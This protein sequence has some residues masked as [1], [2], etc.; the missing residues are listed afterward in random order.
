MGGAGS[1]G[2]GAG[3]GNGG[4]G[5]SLVA[6]GTL[7]TVMLLDGRVSVNGN[8]VGGNY[9]GGGAGGGIVVSA[10]FLQGSGELSADG[11]YGGS[12]GG[13]GG[14]GG[15][16]AIHASNS[17]F[18][19]NQHVCGGRYANSGSSTWYRNGAAGTLFQAL[20][21][22]VNDRRETLV[23]DNCGLDGSQ[24]VLMGQ[25][26]YEFVVATL[27]NKGRLSISNPSTDPDSRAFLLIKRL[28]GDGSGSL[29]VVDKTDFMVL[30]PEATALVQRPIATSFA[31]P[32]DGSLQV[33]RDERVWF[34]E[35]IT[36][37]MVNVDVQ[38]GA[39]LTLPPRLHVTNVNF[40]LAGALKG[41]TYFLAGL[42]S[43]ITFE[44]SAAQGDNAS[45]KPAG[46]WSFLVMRITRDAQF[47]WHSMRR[48][49]VEVK[50]EVVDEA[51]LQL[52]N[53]NYAT[54]RGP[55]L[56]INGTSHV[57]FTGTC[58]WDATDNLIIGRNARLTSVGGGGQS[59]HTTDCPS[60]GNSG[61]GGSHAGHGGA[62]SGSYTVSQPCDSYE[63]PQ[64]VG[65]AG[66]TWSGSTGKG[67]GGV[68]LL[69]NRTF[70]SVL[71]LDGEVNMAATAGTSNAGG[72]AGGS[73]AVG[74]RYFHGAGSMSVTGGN[75]RGGGS[76][77]RIAV[78]ATFTHGPDPDNVPWAGDV[79]AWGGDGSVEDGAA[80]SVFWSVGVLA[81]QRFRRLYVDNNNR[82]GRNTA[83]LD[84]GREVYEFDRVFIDRKAKLTFSPPDTA[85]AR[86]VLNIKQLGGD[87]SGT[88]NVPDRGDVQI[89]GPI[90]DTPAAVP[91]VMANSWVNSYARAITRHDVFYPTS[92]RLYVVN[93]VVG[94]QGKVVFPKNLVVDGVSLDV[95]GELSGVEWLAVKNAGSMYL[96]GSSRQTNSTA[97]YWNFKEINIIQDSSLTM[98]NVQNITIANRVDIAD[99]SRYTLNGLAPQD[100]GSWGSAV[101]KSPYITFNDTSVVTF[102]GR[103]VLD[104]RCD[105]ALPVH[106]ARV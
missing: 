23:V 81:S 40:R 4:A 52:T 55:E 85:P 25:I 34:S 14:S 1:Q 29:V 12:S 24:T 16:I 61:A 21:R 83:L 59:Q 60:S 97:G 101:I 28:E 103:L 100:D 80:G 19:G 63:W 105:P 10:F 87:G 82:V 57:H 98:D 102:E 35:A 8:N 70:A 7:D 51:T 48:L 44:A 58:T 31:L 78:H 36:L 94:T 65:Q 15:R 79:Y 46:L 92:Y 56:E 74:A 91:V 47:V 3:G 84:P 68:T 37:D 42:G 90:S 86:A 77:G 62:G 71:L 39:T 26:S 38:S 106:C 64:F 72:G 73:I 104:V 99:D 20:G 5:I 30:G 45:V 75:G 43:S 54:F 88:L 50:F 9:G 76:G 66:Q 17:S 33:T 6:N 41:V 22:D 11:G 93:M 49:D 95:Y 67:G 32:G 2:S 96:R 27:R 18:T 13:G 89:Q 53:L 69:C